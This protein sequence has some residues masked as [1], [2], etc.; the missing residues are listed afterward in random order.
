MG[1]AAKYKKPVLLGRM[2]PDGKYLKGSIRN[3]DGGA[4]RNLKT[5]LLNSGLMEYVEGH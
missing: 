1:V 5:F 3:K 2:T 4:L